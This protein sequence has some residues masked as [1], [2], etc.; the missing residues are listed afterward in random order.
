MSV[1]FFN[2]LCAGC[3]A[4]HPA[5][6]TEVDYKIAPVFGQCKALYTVQTA[7]YSAQKKAQAWA[8]LNLF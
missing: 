7:L 1:S 3:Q 4:V 6:F 8:Q 2:L 5:H